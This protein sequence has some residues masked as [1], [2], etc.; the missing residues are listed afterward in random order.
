MSNKE[1]YSFSKLDT[2]HNCKRNYYYNYI[3][4]QRGGDSIYSFLGTVVHEL[5]QN[6]IEKNISNEQAI[7]LFIQ[8]V[9]DAEMLDLPWISEN[10]K[11]NYVTCITHF[12]ENFVPV[13]NNTIRIEDKFEI[14][15]NG[16]ILRGFIDLWYRIKNK[17]YIIDLKTSTKFSKKDFPKK[18]RQLLLYAIA[19]SEKY[20]DYEITLQFNMLKY[21]LIN[22]KLKERNKLGILD[23]DF[24]DGIIEV[25]V[26]DESIQE[27]KDYVVNTVNSINEINKNDIVYWDM[28]YNPSVDFFCKNLCSHRSKCLNS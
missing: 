11:N 7:E 10:V 15:I 18:A 14:E 13:E 1:L 16:I 27:V 6:M 2:F 19:L 5:T 4:K 25:D 21:V 9:D 28:D 23:D 24:S 17:I 8:A 22:G 3:L 20:P 12:L 26:N